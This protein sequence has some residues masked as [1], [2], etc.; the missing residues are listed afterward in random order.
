[1]TSVNNFDLQNNLLLSICSFVT[2]LLYSLVNKIHDT[3]VF[4][5][6]NYDNILDFIG[7]CVNTANLRI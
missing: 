5:P 3:Y 7:T 2:D 6:S 1:M 4:F